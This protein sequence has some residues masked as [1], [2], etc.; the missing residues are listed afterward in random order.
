MSEKNRRVA[1][2]GVMLES[3]AFSPIAEEADFRNALYVTGAD[4]VVEARKSVSTVPREMAAFVQT[5]DATGPWTPVPLLLTNCPPWGPVNGEFFT[6]C[7][8]QIIAGLEAAGP[9]DGV[10]IANHGA[11]VATDDGDPDGT[12]MTAIR[13]AVGGDVAVIATLD[14]HANISGAM[15]AATD[16]IIGYQTNPHVDQ[17]Q[18]GEE[19]ALLMRQM[20]AGM[21]PIQN[22]IR[23]PLVPPSTTLLTAAGPY[24]ELIDY[25]QRRAREE[26]GEIVNVSVFGNFAFSDCAKNGLS[27]VVTARTD[28]DKAAGLAN[29]IATRAW[30]N[31]AAFSR[32]LTSIDEA[33]TLANRNE[34]TPIIFSDAGDNPGGGG[35]GRTTWLL[36]A[37]VAGG[38]KGVYYGAFFDQELALE[39]HALGEGA[40]FDAVFNRTG[41]TEFSKRFECKAEVLKLH[42]GD[43]VGRLGI[44]KD[45]RLKLGPC[46]ALQI[47]GED[48]ITVVVISARHQAADPMF[49]EMFG[50]DIAQART[51][52]VKSRGHFRAG[53]IPWFP[54]EHVY[55][56]DTAGLTSPVLSRFQWRNLPRP[57]YPMDPDTDWTPPG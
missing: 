4:I 22:F 54:P 39:A 53:F 55:E 6:A 15:A 34:G 37:L 3:N 17:V 23:L 24:G 57:V 46:A 20:F 18:R 30:N 35:E 31:R 7:V 11:M 32:E 47:G 51:V 1:L 56:V 27:I 8:A 50:L 40:T 19:A 16:A 49:F 33:V 29:E 43:M 12:L 48:G 25:G 5:M 42:D 36:A 10:Y 52:C 14:L 2:C 38:A 13:D 45:R 26:A 28:V 21:R 44:Y 41:D 9:L